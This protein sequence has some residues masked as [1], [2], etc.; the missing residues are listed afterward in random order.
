[1]NPTFPFPAVKFARLFFPSQATVA[2]CTAETG[3]SEEFTATSKPTEVGLNEV[4]TMQIRR[5]L[6]R[7]NVLTKT[8][9]IKSS[10][11]DSFFLHNIEYCHLI[12]CCLRSA[13]AVELGRH[14]F[15]NCSYLIDKFLEEEATYLALLESDNT[16]GKR[17]K[18]KRFYEIKKKAQR[19]FNKD[20]AAGATI[21]SA[22]SSSSS[23]RYQGYITINQLSL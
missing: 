23:P 15:P 11:N 21:P 10:H 4:P 9:S 18:R 16:D 20:I 19:A 13:S 6:K 8:G 7:F 3:T 12:N 17:I 14:Y 5:L 22:S 2:M 1:M